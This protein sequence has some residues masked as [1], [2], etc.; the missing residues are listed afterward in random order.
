MKPERCFVGFSFLVQG[1]DARTGRTVPAPSELVVQ[2][3]GIQTAHDQ[4]LGGCLLQAAA[5]HSEGEADSA[6]LVAWSQE[7]ASPATHQWHITEKRK[8]L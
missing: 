7:T 6:P 3:S 2:G 8:I 5:A 4:S 1:R